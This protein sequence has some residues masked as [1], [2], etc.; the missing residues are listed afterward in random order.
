[1]V[2]YRAH[3]GRSEFKAREAT[4]PGDAAALPGALEFSLFRDS[5]RIIDLDAEVTHS[6]FQFGMTQQELHGAQIACLFVDQ[7]RFSPPQRMCTV[8]ARIKTNARDPAT[9]DPCILAG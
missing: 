6:T 9:H 4:V 2:R 8:F 5:Q 3:T 7:R 1:M